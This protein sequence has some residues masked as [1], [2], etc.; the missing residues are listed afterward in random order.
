M[1]MQYS[2][3]NVTINIVVMLCLL[4]QHTITVSVSR[5]VSSWSLIVQLALSS[6]ANYLWAVKA[7]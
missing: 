7:H 2:T 6:S 5:S 1:H 4:L 3:A